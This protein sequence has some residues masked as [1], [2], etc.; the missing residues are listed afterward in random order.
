MNALKIKKTKELRKVL[1]LIVSAAIVLLLVLSFFTGDKDL[2][3]TLYSV[4]TAL[5]ATIFIAVIFKSSFGNK[6][7]L[8]EIEES[9]FWKK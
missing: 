5:L 9:Q 3:F 8:D 7:T 6:K 1:V 4:S 2:K